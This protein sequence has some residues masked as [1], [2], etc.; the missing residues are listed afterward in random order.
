[1]DPLGEQLGIPEQRQV[2]EDRVVLGEGHVVR[3]AR[4]RQRDVDRVLE[5]AVG[6]HHAVVHVGRLLAVAEHEELAGALVE[7]GVG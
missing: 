5:P 7:L 4:T 3:Q 6:A 1:M 2:V